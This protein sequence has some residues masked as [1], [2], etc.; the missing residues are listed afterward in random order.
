MDD[1]DEYGFEYANDMFNFWCRGRAIFPIN[2]LPL[3]K[4]V[5]PNELWHSV[6]F[7]CHDYDVVS[8]LEVSKKEKWGVFVKWEFI[9]VNKKSRI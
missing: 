9:G 8:L 2:K 1:E 3:Q 6:K 7:R 5:N 4:D